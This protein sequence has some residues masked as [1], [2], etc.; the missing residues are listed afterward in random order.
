MYNAAV[1]RLAKSYAKENLTEC[2]EEILEWQSTSVLRA[3]KVRELANVLRPLVTHDAL[4][5][6]ESLVMKAA[7]EK[8]A[9]KGGAE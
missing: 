8:I 2:C 6:A 5:V 4:R 1:M 3:G 9:G 7:M